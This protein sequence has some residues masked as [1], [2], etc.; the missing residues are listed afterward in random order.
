[1][2]PRL[3]VLGASLLK[4]LDLELYQTDVCGGDLAVS[5]VRS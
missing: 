1:M 4:W 3:R 2:A 5:M